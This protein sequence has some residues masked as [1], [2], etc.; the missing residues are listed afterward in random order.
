MANRELRFNA[1]KSEYAII[2]GFRV[3]ARVGG[4]AIV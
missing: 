4:P 3:D 2:C 1:N